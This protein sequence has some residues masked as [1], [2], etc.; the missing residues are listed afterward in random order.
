MIANQAKV[1]PRTEAVNATEAPGPGRCAKLNE[2]A[3]AGD[4]GRRGEP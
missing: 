3:G 1:A 2:T 4:A